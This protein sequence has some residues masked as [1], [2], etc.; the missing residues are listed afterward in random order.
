MKLC[1]ADLRQ[2][3]NTYQFFLDIQKACDSVWCNGLWNK[4]WDIDVSGR[5]WHVIKKMYGS[6]K[7]A[8]I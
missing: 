1:K 8:V 2:N 3:K 6:S 5:M 7:S 4:L